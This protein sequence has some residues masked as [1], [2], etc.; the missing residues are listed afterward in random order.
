MVWAARECPAKAKLPCARHPDLEQRV[1]LRVVLEAGGQNGPLLLGE[2][3][4]APVGAALAGARDL[5]PGAPGQHR[6]LLPPLLLACIQSR[7]SQPGPAPAPPLLLP[8]PTLPCTYPPPTATH[9]CRPAS[10]AAAS[11]SHS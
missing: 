2:D 6:R 8:A 10:R 9:S 11:P 5:H 3:G 1:G 4:A 7:W